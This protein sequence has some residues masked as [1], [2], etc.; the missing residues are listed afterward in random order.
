MDSAGLGDASWEG[1]CGADAD[2]LFP[3]YG[4]PSVGQSFT[5]TFLAL[6][7]FDRRSSAVTTYWYLV[8]PLS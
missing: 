3:I 5:F 8:L 6:L 1:Q 7:S 2:P 4:V